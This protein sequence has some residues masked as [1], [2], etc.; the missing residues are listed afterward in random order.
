MTT[1]VAVCGDFVTEHSDPFAE[2]TNVYWV[3]LSYLAVTSPPL[4]L[5][6]IAQLWG[7]ALLVLVLAWGFRTLRKVAW[8]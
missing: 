3:E 4:S 7:A 1:L 6:D 8:R 2:C 5:D